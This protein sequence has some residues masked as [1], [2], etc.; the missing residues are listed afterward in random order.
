V[1]IMPYYNLTAERP[2]MHM[3]GSCD[4]REHKMRCI[5]DCTHYCYTPEARGPLERRAPGFL[6]PALLLISTDQHI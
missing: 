6:P 5:C 4:V 1:R 3:E 2:D